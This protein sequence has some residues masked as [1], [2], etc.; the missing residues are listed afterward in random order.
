MKLVSYFTRASLGAF[1]LVGSTAF[2]AGLCQTKWSD[3]QRKLDDPSNRLAFVNPPGP[4]SIGLCWWHS[5]MQR[6]SNYLLEFQAKAARPNANQSWQIIKN[7]SRTD[8]VQVVPGFNNLREFSAVYSA[9]MTEALGQWQMSDSFL[10]FGW[11]NGLGSSQPSAESMSQEMDALY[12]AV[13]LK[14]N[15]VYQM[16]KMPGVSAHAWL[17]TEMKKVPNGYNLKVIDSNSMRVELYSYQRG[18]TF[19]NYTIGGF[20]YSNMNF[21]PHTQRDSELNDYASALNGACG[22]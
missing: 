2:G 15:V 13:T 6:N 17:V 12:E 20:G 14:R 21:A 8:Q 18:M 19:F 4:M 10:K 5:R 9:E 3:F 16:L 22:R 1:L 11:A 7:L